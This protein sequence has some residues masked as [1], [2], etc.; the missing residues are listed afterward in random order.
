MDA[1][2]KAY[3][4]RYR[5][6]PATGGI[7]GASFIHGVQSLPAIDMLGVAAIAI[8]SADQ[9]LQVEVFLIITP[10]SV[11]AAVSRT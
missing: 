7:P 6:W 1:K 11:S 4:G 3:H 5:A 2:G 10:K 9:M 8:R